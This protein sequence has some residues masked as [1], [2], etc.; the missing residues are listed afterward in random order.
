MLKIYYDT[1]DVFSLEAYISTSIFIDALA[2]IDLPITNQKIAGYLEGLKNYDYQGLTLTF[3]PQ[4]RSLS[5]ALWLED[6]N[7]PEW[8]KCKIEQPFHKK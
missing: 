4:T 8:V 6:N 7:Q 2:K 1:F 3:N 5:N